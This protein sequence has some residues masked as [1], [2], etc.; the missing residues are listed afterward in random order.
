MQFKNAH[1][2]KQLTTIIGVGAALLLSATVSAHAYT[3]LGS[4]SHIQYVKVK[5]PLFTGQYTKIHGKKGQPIITPKGTILQVESTTYSGK[6][7]SHALLSR[8]VISY[9]KQQRIYQPDNSYI[10][11]YNTKYFSPYKLRLPVR[12][13]A[14]QAGKGFTNNKAGYYKPIFYITLDGYLQYYTTPR[15]KHYGAQN[16]WQSTKGVPAVDN[17][18]WTIKPSVSEKIGTFKSKGNTSYV[19]YQKPIKGLAAKKVSAKYYRLTIKKGQTQNKIWHYGDED[20]RL[21]IWTN[22]TVGGNPFYNLVE[23]SEAD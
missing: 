19:Y 9:Q 20:T 6:G 17:P 11:H 4:N 14:L 3:D 21:G 13:L 1:L 12:T 18:I 5:R 10:K 22:Y 15:L 16:S 7:P 2:V 23:V 8:G